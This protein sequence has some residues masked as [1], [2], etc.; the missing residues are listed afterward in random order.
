M[1]EAKGV[2]RAAMV[3]SYFMTV[4]T[5][6]LCLMSTLPLIWS[7]VM[8]WCWWWALPPGPA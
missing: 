4:V 2:V 3:V 5:V 1:R 6:T 8:V 7:T